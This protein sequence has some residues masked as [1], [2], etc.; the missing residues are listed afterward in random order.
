[1]PILLRL[2][3]PDGGFLRAN[4]PAEQRW[5]SRDTAAMARALGLDDAAP[6][7]VD[8]ADPAAGA[9]HVNADD[10]PAGMYAPPARWPVPGLTV[11]HFRDQHL[12]YALTWYALAV[13][14]AVA[15]GYGVRLERRRRRTEQGA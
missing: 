10:V 14:T 13:M 2:S 1:L 7:F 8:Q 15:I 5:Y 3:Q 4:V 6:Y 9:V 12:S 11:V